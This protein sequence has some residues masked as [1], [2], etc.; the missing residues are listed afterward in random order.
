MKKSGVGIRKGGFSVDA[1]LKRILSGKVGATVLFVGS[2]RNSSSEGRVRHLDF[3]AYGPMARK[4]LE[5]IR[6]RAIRKF[7]VEDIA[8]IHRVGRIRA[9]DRIVL[10]AASAAH[11]DA[12]FRACRYVLEELKKHAPIWK[13]ERGVWTGPGR[14]GKKGGVKG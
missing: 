4:E 8:V 3:Q 2:V 1:A 12:A 5:E 14:K 6:K 9:G 13:K 10:V 11:R 7:N